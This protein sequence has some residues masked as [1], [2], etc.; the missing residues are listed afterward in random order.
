M[1]CKGRWGECHRSSASD[2]PAGKAR[3]HPSGRRRVALHAS[4]RTGVTCTKLCSTEHS[5]GLGVSAGSFGRVGK[6]KSEPVFQG[7]DESL[8]CFGWPQKT[9]A[10]SRKKQVF[11]VIP[12]MK[13]RTKLFN[14]GTLIS[15]TECRYGSVK[16]I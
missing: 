14:S 2:S 10:V 7:G 4:G 13:P 6:G 12:S 11:S 8:S 3:L 5:K 1:G 16:G 15:S 9:T